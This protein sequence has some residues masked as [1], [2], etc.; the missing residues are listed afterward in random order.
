MKKYCARCGRNRDVRFFTP[1]KSR[2]D[3]LTSSCND[4]HRR[5]VREHY[6]KNKSIYIEKAKKQT[7]VLRQLINELKSVPCMDCGNRYSPWV[8]DFDHRDGTVKD[9]EVAKLVSYGSK[10]RILEEVK[11]C[12]VVCSNCHRE[13]THRRRKMEP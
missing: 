3:G 7:L 11:K 6:G 8:M 10:R 4:C 13:R 9:L 1:N 12:D 5:Y 2:Y